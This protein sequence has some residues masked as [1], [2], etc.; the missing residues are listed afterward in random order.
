MAIYLRGNNW[1]IDFTFKGQRVRE[2][3]GPSRKDAGKVVAKR[4]TE[5][6]E[7]KYLDIRKEPEP[8]KIYDFIKEYLAWAKINKKPSTYARDIG[9][10]RLFEAEFQGKTLQDIT[11]WL[12]EKYKSKRKEKFKPASVNRELAVIKHFFSRAVEWGKLRENPAKKLKL[13]KGVTKRV[14]YLLSAEIQTLLPNCEGALEGLL[15]PM[16]TVAVHT[17][18]RKSEVVNLEWNRVNFEM[19]IISLFNADTKNHERRDI[20]MDET[21]KV[22]LQAMERKGDLVFCNGKGKAVCLTLLQSA[23]HEALEKSGIT[24]F[25]F[26]DLRHTFASNLAMQEGVELN[27]VR[28]LLGHKTMDMTL[29][30]AHLSPRHKTRVVTILD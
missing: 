6:I 17:G 3:I 9:I 25:H 18:M 23:F 1:Y 21:V 26:H 14:R 19:G 20:P 30:Y 16:V 29:R 12:L 13:F 7:N 27:D 10:L 24:D 28:E 22:T 11:P 4:K 5:I 15:K 2:S 8:V